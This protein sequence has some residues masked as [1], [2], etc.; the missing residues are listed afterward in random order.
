MSAA[1]GGPGLAPTWCSS[2]KEIVGCPLG[3]AR[4][5]DG[6]LVSS[7]LC[8]GQNLLKQA[9]GFFIVAVERRRHIA[10]E[11]HDRRALLRSRG[12]VADPR[13][14]IDL[15][16]LSSLRGSARAVAGIRRSDHRVRPREPCDRV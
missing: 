4:L 2:D 10:L 6:L 5:D 16:R 15:G 9:A 3:P 8:V 11:I 13:D 7:G 1:P 12:V 14:R